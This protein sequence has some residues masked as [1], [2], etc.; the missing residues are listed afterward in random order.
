[1]AFRITKTGE[2]LLRDGRKA[3]VTKIAIHDHG[4]HKIEGYI[5]EGSKVHWTEYG[6]FDGSHLRFYEPKPHPTHDIIGA[7]PE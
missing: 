2:Y 4:T 6:F 1:M 7:W 5:I 3:I